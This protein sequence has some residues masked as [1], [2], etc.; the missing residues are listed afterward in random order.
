MDGEIKGVEG[1]EGMSS[2]VFIFDQ[3]AGVEGRKRG[4]QVR[5][6]EV[7]WQDQRIVHEQQG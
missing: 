1:G 5:L 3:G 6:N 7:E 4:E 2:E